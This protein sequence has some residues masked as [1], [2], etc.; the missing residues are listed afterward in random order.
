MSEPS[1]LSKLICASCAGALALG[2]CYSG[3]PASLASMIGALVVCCWLWWRHTA[4]EDLSAAAFAGAFA[5]IVEFVGGG[6]GAPHSNVP[7]TVSSAALALVAGAALYFAMCKRPKVEA[8]LGL[9]AHLEP[10]TSALVAVIAILLFNARQVTLGR[11]AGTQLVG[12][13]FAYTFVICIAAFVLTARL[14]RRDG[15]LG[16]AAARRALV[17]LF[18]LAGLALLRAI[19]AYDYLGIFYASAIVGMLGGR[20]HNNRK[21]LIST[22][23]VLI[24]SML[25]VTLL[26]PDEIT[27]SRIAAL[28]SAIALVVAMWLAVIF[29]DGDARTPAA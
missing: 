13:G 14:S 9:S 19:Q 22:S 17:A 3:V 11:W 7:L 1:V 25:F 12:L 4:G 26:A 2:L 16:N 23:A 29:S 27:G 28:V 24:G 21:A 5:A 6:L 18:A 10:A 8:N 20:M 15:F